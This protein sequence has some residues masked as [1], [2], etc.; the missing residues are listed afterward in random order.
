MNA[1]RIPGGLHGKTTEFYSVMINDQEKA[2]C[3]FGGV[4]HSFNEAPACRKSIL[5]IRL[6]ELPEARKA[7]VAMV[8]FD[9]DRILEQMTICRYG[10]LNDEPDIDAYGILSEP[11]YVPCAKRGL[12]DHEGSGC[13]SLM[14]MGVILSKCETLVFKLCLSSDIEISDKLFI[15]VETVKKHFQNIRLKTGF[16][17]KLEMVHYATKKNII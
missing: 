12:C 4:Q 16:K 6:Q 9:E 1:N 17:N 3:L 15:S 7:Y 5:R 2:I 14:V 8:G 10:L 11:E 13:C